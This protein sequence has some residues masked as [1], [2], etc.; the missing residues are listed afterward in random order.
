[1]TDQLR[2]PTSGKGSSGRPSPFRHLAPLALGLVAGSVIFYGAYYAYGIW[3]H[4]QAQAQALA[5][6]GDPNMAKPSPGECA[7]AL[8]AL[9]SIHASGADA[10][11]RADSK[12]KQ[13][14]LATDSKVINPADVSGYSDEESD[15]LRDKP[16]A[17]WRWCPGMA[18]FVASLGW[19]A[20][21]GDDYAS[22]L[23]LGRPGVNKAGDEATV[24]EV[25]LTPRGYG[26]V[27]MRFRGPWL[28]SLH[29]GPDGAWQVTSTAPMKSANP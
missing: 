10:R 1:V 9:A 21:G 29:R 19:S 28:A 2:D 25:F 5:T 4:R 13:M 8:A 22:L 11:W 16:A 18:A 17:D 6:P 3:S 26:G 15:D 27:L 14:S 20:M 24:Y 12:V 7:V 23:G